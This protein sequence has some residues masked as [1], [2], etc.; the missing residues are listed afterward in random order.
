MIYLCAQPDSFYFLWQVEILINNL[1]NLKVKPENIHVLI[2]YDAAT[3]INIEWTQFASTNSKY[4]RF[5]FYSD[6]R[7]SKKYLS[8]IRPHI[9]RK[10]LCNLPLA[11]YIQN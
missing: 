1:N 8:S 11:S 5:H 3:G 10:H 6:G 7:I 4:A 9:I 2:G